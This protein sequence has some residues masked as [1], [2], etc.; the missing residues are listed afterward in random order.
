MLARMTPTSPANASGTQTRTPPTVMRLPTIPATS[1]RLRPWHRR[2]CHSPHTVTPRPRMSRGMRTASRNRNPRPT[3][4][5]PPMTGATPAQH[6]N[7][8]A[9]PTRPAPV[10]R[11]EARVRF[12]MASPCRIVLRA[13][14]RWRS[15]RPDASSPPRL[16][17]V[18]QY[19]PA[20]PARQQENGYAARAR[21]TRRNT[22]SATSP[23]PATNQ[24]Q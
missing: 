7:A 5:S 23:T 3:A 13:R 16:G 15:R 20:Y 2:P 11:R 1:G 12:T 6:S 24:P 8:T 10:A 4:E 21:R 22:T 14:D 17:Y 19:R 18:L 9:D